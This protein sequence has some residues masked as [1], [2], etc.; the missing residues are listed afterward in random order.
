MSRG[1]ASLAF[2]RFIPAKLQN[3]LL[4]KLRVGGVDF[5]L[6]LLRV[7]VEVAFAEGE[8]ANP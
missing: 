2:G 1:V 3:T 8:N 5:A 6:A 7:P 4:T